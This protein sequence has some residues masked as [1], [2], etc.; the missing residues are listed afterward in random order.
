MFIIGF[1]DII[2]I[3]YIQSDSDISGI[4]Y[5][6]T[7]KMALANRKDY[8]NEPFLSDKGLIYVEGI[9]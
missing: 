7:C 1:K 9:S 2:K 8:S 5:P 6:V 3:M 4:Y